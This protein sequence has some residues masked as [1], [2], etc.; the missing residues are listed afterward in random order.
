MENR[1]HSV[2]WDFNISGYSVVNYKKLVCIVVF[3]ME[4][5]KRCGITLATP[6]QI[7]SYL[8]YPGTLGAISGIS[9]LE[10]LQL[11]TDT[12]ITT[13]NYRY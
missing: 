3:S 9:L 7:N 12:A 10:I 6:K 5:M 8:S 4:A 2:N 13:P 1:W 11:A